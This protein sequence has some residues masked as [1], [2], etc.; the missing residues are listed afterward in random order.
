MSDKTIKFKYRVENINKVSYVFCYP[1]DNIDIKY[2]IVF[3][4]PN[5]WREV[6][7]ADIHSSDLLFFCCWYH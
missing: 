3:S 2:H 4:L 5:R 6:Y 1:T 7:G